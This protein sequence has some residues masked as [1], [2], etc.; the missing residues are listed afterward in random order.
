MQ[1]K[2]KSKELQAKQ[3]SVLSAYNEAETEFIRKVSSQLS[4]DGTIMRS[5]SASFE[6]LSLQR[7]LRTGPPWN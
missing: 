4:E 6:C 5:A 1:L 2:R 7:F 3:A